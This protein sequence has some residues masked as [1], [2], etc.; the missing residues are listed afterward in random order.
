[1]LPFEGLDD[2]HR[3][4]FV[5]N[6]SGRFE[7]RFSTLTIEESPAIMLEGMAGS[8]LG[9]WVAHGEGRALFPDDAVR[10]RVAERTGTRPEGPVRMLTHLRTFGHVFN[11]VTFYYVYGTD[12]DRLVIAQRLERQRSKSK[13]W[14]IY[15]FECDERGR[16]HYIH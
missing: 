15:C 5:Q 11:P 8:S 14:D 9:V 2:E 4:R 10:D 13:R 12:G 7:S 3:V 16:L 6:R 1:M